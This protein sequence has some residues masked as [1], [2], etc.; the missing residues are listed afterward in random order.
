VK[1]ADEE[2][3]EEE[4][5][6]DRVGDDED[7]GERLARTETHVYTSVRRHTYRA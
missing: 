7:G 6:A 3:D 2:E 5:R 4:G 1:D